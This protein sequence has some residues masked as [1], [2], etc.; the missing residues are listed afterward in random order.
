MRWI[1]TCFVVLFTACLFTGC[2][3]GGIESGTPTTVGG[4]PSI[5]PPGQVHKPDMGTDGK[6]KANTAGL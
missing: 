2:G 6:K 1:G 3:G 5:D 4:A